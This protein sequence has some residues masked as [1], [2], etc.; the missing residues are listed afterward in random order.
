[1]NSVV[2]TNLGDGIAA[3]GRYDRRETDRCVASWRATT[4]S[5]SF[6]DARSRELQYGFREQYVPRFRRVACPT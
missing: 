6:H 2:D 1:M 5:Y 4:R 3:P